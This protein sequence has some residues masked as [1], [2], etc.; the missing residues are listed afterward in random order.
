MTEPS[1]PSGDAEG[2]PPAPPARSGNGVGADVPGPDRTG[3]RSAAAGAAGAADAGHDPAA[4]ELP[5]A[6]SARRARAERA[7]H[8][9]LSAALILEALTVLFV[10]RTIAP[11][12]DDGLTGGRLALLLGLAG[13][14]VVASGLQRRPAGRVLGSLLQVPVIV[15]GFLIGVM[16]VLGVLFAGVWIYLLRMRLKLLG[17]ARPPA[18]P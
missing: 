7:V 8:G 9:T 5:A 2:R 13:A 11:L 17:S 16:F 1:D 10:P 4:G 6:G 18:G 12:S 14:L 15:T 3:K